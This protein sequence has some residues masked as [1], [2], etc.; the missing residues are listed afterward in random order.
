MADKSLN[1]STENLSNDIWGHK[2]GYRDTRLIVHPDNSVEMTG[3]RYNLCGYR[4]PYLIPFAEEALG[5][6]LDFSRVRPSV[7]NP[8]VTPAASN[9]G[10]AAALA[11]I[12]RPD[13]FTTDD[14]ERL[15]HSH[16]QTT[17][18]EVCIVLYYAIDRS[19]DLVIWP[20]S[21]EECVAIVKAATEHGVCLI[22][23]GGGT[24]VSSALLVP[25]SETRLVASVDMRRLDKIEWVDKENM[26]AC[27]QAGIL[28]SKLEADLE[29]MG[30]TCGHEP[31]SVELSTLGG[32]IAT[33]ASGMKKNRYGNIEDIVENA[34]LVTPAG[35]VEELMPMPRVSM[36]M[37]VNKSLFGSEGNLGLITRAVIRVRTLPAVKKYNAVLFKDWAT[38][39]AFMRELNQTGVLPASIRLVD[40][41]QFRFGQALKPAPEGGLHSLMDRIQKTFVVNIKGFDPLRM[42]AATVVSEGADHEV[43]HQESVVTRLAKKHGGLVAGAENGQRGYMLTY[44]IAYIR[45]LLADYYIVGET[46]ETT[47]PWSKIDDVVSAVERTVLEQHKAYGFPGK[48]YASPRIT[49]MYPTGVCI[50]FTHGFYHKGIDRAEEKFAAMEKEIRRAILNAGGSISHHHGIGKLRAEFMPRILSPTAI[51]ALRDLKQGLDPNNIFG[52]RNNIFHE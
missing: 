41:V 4:M 37:Q 24:N 45:D 30:L 21:H 23:Y 11:S 10:F 5:V 16:G 19:V 28:G 22:P 15:L 34:T 43:A 2:W 7:E 3:S 20:E 9:P 31:D 50:Y 51:E 1:R 12:L 35:V 49:Q 13:Q 8:P 38:G 17:V 52:V 48:P 44:A 27:V 40:N 29:K 33:N 32:W 18:D 36:G 39:V 47:V 14:N 46:Y 42:V 25:E 26:I 6:K